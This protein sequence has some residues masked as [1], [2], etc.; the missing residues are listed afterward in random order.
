ML[1][2]K[3]LNGQDDAQDHGYHDHEDREVEAAE[4]GAPPH[5]SNL[6]PNLPQMLP[7]R[8]GPASPEV[9]NRAPCGK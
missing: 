3:L 4:G 2:R 6:T 8:G 7:R 1:Q 9:V 5:E